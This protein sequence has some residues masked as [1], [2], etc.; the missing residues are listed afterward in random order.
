MNG[1]PE[2]MPLFFAILDG[3]DPKAWPVY[4]KTFPKV[5]EK[6]VQPHAVSDDLID[7]YRVHIEP[8]WSNPKE[9]L[10]EKRLDQ[11]AGIIIEALPKPNFEQDLEQKLKMLRTHIRR[12]KLKTKSNG[13]AVFKR[14]GYS[15]WFITDKPSNIKEFVRSVRQTA[16]MLDEAPTINH[17]FFMAEQALLEHIATYLSNIYLTLDRGD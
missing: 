14:F 5:M 11:V 12:I 10:R 4:D 15:I 7:D 9:L 16:S 1:N 3:P 8:I 13:E 17:Q 2:D 6:A